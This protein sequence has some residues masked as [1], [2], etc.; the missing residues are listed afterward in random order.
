VR[1]PEGLIIRT[2][3]NLGRVACEGHAGDSLGVRLQLAEALSS[4]QLPDLMCKERALSNCQ[5]LS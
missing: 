4:L 3:E 5:G 1:V 2:R